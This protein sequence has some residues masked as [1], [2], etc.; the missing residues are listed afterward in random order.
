MEII[1]PWLGNGGSVY[2]MLGMDMNW[3]TEEGA[4]NYYSTPYIILRND[5]AKEVLNNKFVGN[6]EDISPNF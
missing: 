5:K 1:K 3:N 6:G 2:T 4:K